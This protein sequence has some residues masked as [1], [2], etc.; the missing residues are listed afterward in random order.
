MHCNGVSGVTHRN[1][2]SGA[3]LDNGAV[4]LLFD[5]D[6]TLLRNAS[7]AHAN[8]LSVAMREVHE[9]RGAGDGARALPRVQAAGRTDMEIAREIALLCDLPA[10]RFDELRDEL[11]SVWL[12]EYVRLVE[13]DLSD[14]VVEGMAGLLSELQGADGV[15]LSLVTG[16][17]EGIAKV[18][19]DRAGL[20]SFFSPW[21]GGFG[22]DSDNRTDLPSIA[23]ERAGAMFGDGPYP[24]ERT[25]VIG[26][27]SRDVACA[28][29]DGVRCVA[30]T[31]GPHGAKDLAGADAIAE[32]VPQ[33]RE[34][35]LSY[36]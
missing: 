1:G 9:L 20:R 4:L 10:K 33:L 24:R 28:R 31:T 13:D 36:V 17:L 11:M 22:S 18:K 3:I 7:Q 8:A 6:G 19:L 30:V 15:I 5:I 35:L 16:N 34:L 26:D 23:R 29:A 2:V 14:R 12:R 27:T 21:Q 25:I 32:D